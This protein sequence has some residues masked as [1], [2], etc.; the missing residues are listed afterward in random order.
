MGKKPSTTSQ[1][2]SIKNK[3]VRVRTVGWIQK[4]NVSNKWIPVMWVN[5]ETN[6][7]NLCNL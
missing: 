5:Q 4:Q 2:F 1:N 6:A 3:F 7:M